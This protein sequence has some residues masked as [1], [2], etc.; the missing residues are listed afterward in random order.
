[1]IVET[2]LHHALMCRP[3]V[4][5]PEGH[6]DVTERA[7]WCDKRGFHLVGLLHPDLVVAGVGFQETESFTPCG[8][9]HDLFDA[10]QRERVLWECFC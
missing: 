4:V 8:G 3:G 1:M 6:C 10:G 5:E 7:E 9:V 2:F